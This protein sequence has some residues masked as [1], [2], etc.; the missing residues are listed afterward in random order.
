M[1]NKAQF[2]AITLTLSTLGFMLGVLYGR[3]TATTNIFPEN[4]AMQISTSADTHTTTITGSGILDINTATK[5]D[6]VLLPGV[7]EVLAQA[8]IDYRNNNGPFIT[9]QDL[10]NVSGIGDKKLNGML[11]Y[12]TVGGQK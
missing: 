2:A 8:I 6:L 4:Y 7:G 10:L 1:K 12:I 11:N 5:D 3:N 9:V